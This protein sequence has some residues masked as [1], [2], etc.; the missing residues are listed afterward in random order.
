MMKSETKFMVHHTTL[1]GNTTSKFK[2]EK[3]KNIKQELQINL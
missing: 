1:P 3:K 2:Q